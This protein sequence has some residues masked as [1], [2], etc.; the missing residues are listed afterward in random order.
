MRAAEIVPGEI[1]VQHTALNWT[2]AQKKQ[3]ENYQP[4]QVLAF[5]KA[6]KGVA[7]NEAL[8]VVSADQSA[9]TAR[10]A[11]GEILQIT[12]R[13]AK[14][15][16]VFEKQDL[17]I[18]A[19]DKL[20]LQ[21]N[22][23]DK[24]FRATNGELVTVGSV[25][26]GSIQ[27]EDGRRVPAGYRQFTHGYAVTAHRSQGKTVDFEIIAAERMAQDLFYVSATRAREG[28]TVITSDS[29]RLQESIGISG[30]RQSATELARRA[31][32]ANPVDAAAPGDFRLQ[33]AQLLTPKK[34]KYTIISSTR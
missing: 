6:V 29:L 17:E 1:F 18:S 14:A 3:T 4:G 16:A 24:S 21:A 28:L 10:K 19:G 27:L 33:E 7:K 31:A 2:E 34:K 9:I 15:F 32:I 22:W 5:H 20:L 23:R 30:D 26:S 12:T 25:E 8:E 13:Q 11:T